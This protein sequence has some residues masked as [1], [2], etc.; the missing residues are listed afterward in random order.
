[1]SD[2]VGIERISVQ[3]AG[4]R[5][6]H[7]V[8]P[9]L[10]AAL[11][12][13][14]AGELTVGAVARRSGIGV[15]TIYRYFDGADELV[16]VT[17]LLAMSETLSS[18]THAFLAGTSRIDSIDEFQKLT[19]VVAAAQSAFSHPDVIFRLLA[20]IDDVVQH[21]SSDNE[22]RALLLE[23]ALPVAGAIREWQA[24]WVVNDDVE[25]FVTAVAI[26]T[27]GFAGWLAATGETD[28][29]TEL[30]ATIFGNLARDREVRTLADDS[31]NPGLRLSSLTLTAP[32]VSDE[33]ERILNLEIPDATERHRVVVMSALDLTLTN[34]DREFSVAELIAH[35]GIAVKEIY[36]LFREK[37]QIAR[38]ASWGFASAT[39][40][41][42]LDS[43]AISIKS[44]GDA[45]ATERVL[46][47]VLQRF[48]EPNSAK[49]RRI[50]LRGLRSLAAIDEPLAHL[51]TVLSSRD[52]LALAIEGASNAGNL[53]Q[54]ASPTAVANLIAGVPVMRTVNDALGGTIGNAS[55][56]WFLDVTFGQ[57][58]AC[59]D[60]SIFRD[61]DGS[62]RPKPSK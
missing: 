31:W 29:W 54:V 38:I 26:V 56:G 13:L 55:W 33:A 27:M 58:L 34:P 15:A 36:T 14:K 7:R 60:R 8:Q 4:R 40:S 5:T 46:S 17:N 28:Q 30:L 9:I 2:V 23:L 25:S 11:E 19:P 42:Y 22:L 43:A 37:S 24:Y 57:L 32:N 59:S 35:C 48:A 52:Q 3:F 61:Q 6:A 41:A 45:R 10:E 18:V 1:M 12:A 44:A 20:S 49:N 16:R 62:R 50:R 39:I 51:A 47:D 21:G 53:M